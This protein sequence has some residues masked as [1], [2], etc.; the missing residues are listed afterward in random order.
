MKQRKQAKDQ[1]RQAWY[2]LAGSF[3]FIFLLIAGKLLVSPKPICDPEIKSKTVIL[4]DHS[5]VLTETTI[6]AIV[7]RTWA[8]IEEQIPEGERVSVFALPHD[9]KSRSNIALF[10]ECKPRLSGNRA[11]ENV[12]KIKRDFEQKFKNPL[13]EILNS[14]SPGSKESPIAGT[15]ANLSLDDRHF[16]SPDLTRFLIFSDFLENTPKFSLYKCSDFRNAIKQFRD[17][18]AGTLERPTFENVQIYMNIIPSKSVGREALQCRDKFWMWY[19]GGTTCRQVA[20]F[21][22]EYMPE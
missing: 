5:E 7:E 10:E 18:R 2:L 13:R 9:S 1:R 11:I 17:S 19:F 22:P 3:A 21:I 6:N 14:P 16:K 8:F 15:V 20:C 12:K 4:L